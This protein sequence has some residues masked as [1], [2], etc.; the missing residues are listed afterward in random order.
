MSS[1]LSCHLVDLI[2]WPSTRISLTLR[3]LQAFAQA[4]AR[5][6]GRYDFSQ[7]CQALQVG[8]DTNWQRIQEVIRDNKAKNQVF[9]STNYFWNG[10]RMLKWPTASLVRVQDDTKDDG[11]AS[12]APP[13]IYLNEMEFGEK[14]MKLVVRATGGSKQFDRADAARGRVT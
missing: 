12:A 11:L 5:I 13:L 10:W 4:D 7:Q 6:A 9:G 2:A 14:G 8:L 3:Y 1:E